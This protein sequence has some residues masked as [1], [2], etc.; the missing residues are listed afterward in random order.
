MHVRT[1][2]KA[3]I[4]RCIAIPLPLRPVTAVIIVTDQFNEDSDSKSLAL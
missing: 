3:A 2:A 1:S 4:A